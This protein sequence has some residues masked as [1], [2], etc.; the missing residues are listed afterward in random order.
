MN[1][2][3]IM[4]SSSF[5]GRTKWH[6]LENMVGVIDIPAYTDSVFKQR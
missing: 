4:F 6:L 5:L 2:D 1:F 3:Q